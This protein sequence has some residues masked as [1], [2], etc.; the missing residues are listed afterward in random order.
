[1]TKDFYL[2]PGYQDRLKEKHDNNLPW[3]GRPIL[4]LT[5]QVCGKAFY[6]PGGCII[7]YCSYDCEKEAAKQRRAR[8]EGPQPRPCGVCGQTF[9]PGRKGAEYCS[10]A[11]KQKAYRKRRSVTDNL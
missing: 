11:C 6:K 3:L 9:N 2:S 4:K 10:A 7:K 1:M 8:A 5:C